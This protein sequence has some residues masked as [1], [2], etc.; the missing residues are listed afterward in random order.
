MKSLRLLLPMLMLVSFFVACG[1]TTPDTNTTVDNTAVVNTPEPTPE[2][3]PETTAGTT[4][5]AKY[6]SFEFGDAAYYGFETEAGEK[7]TFNRIDDRSLEFHLE[8]PEAEAN[9]DNQ[10]IGANKE[11]L[12]KWF[13]VTYETKQ[14]P[15]YIDGPVGDVLVATKVVAVQ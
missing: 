14:E 1:E 7:I 3:E 6:T 5:K 4:V 15:M 12:D 9:E 11:L 13:T 10:G 8:L 2:P